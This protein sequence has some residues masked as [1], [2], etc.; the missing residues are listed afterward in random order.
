MNVSELA[1]TLRIHPRKMLGILPQHGFDIGAKA[2]KIDDRVANQII[3]QWKH[4]KRQVDEAERREE[5][6]R[7][8]KE[9]ELRREQGH[10]VILPAILTVRQFAERLNLS[11]TAV[12][13]ELMK[14][15]IL[16]NQNQ[17]IDYDT[18]AIMADQFGFSA[19][20]GGVEKKE[21]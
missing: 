2:V 8:Q 21:I 7:K 1:R 17:N 3:H 5:D 16:A 12:I 18:A 4:I 20:K 6:L 13:T 19:A 11:V 9:R 10:S 15:G 14:N